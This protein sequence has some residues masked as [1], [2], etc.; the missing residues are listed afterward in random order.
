MN[1]SCPYDSF[2]F[3]KNQCYKALENAYKEFGDINPYG[4]Y[5]NPCNEL[6]SLSN[7]LK[8]PLVRKKKKKTCFDILFSFDPITRYDNCF[9]GWFFSHGHLEEMIN[10]L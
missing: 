6:G 5:D 8:L 7:N 2:L 9:F 1:E 3:P 10:V 4:I